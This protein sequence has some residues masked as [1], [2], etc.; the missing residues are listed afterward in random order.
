MN[1]NKRVVDL[2]YAFKC[3]QHLADVAVH[4]TYHRGVD[5]HQPYRVALLTSGQLIPRTCPRRTRWTLN[6]LCNQAE[7]LL[8]R[9][10]LRK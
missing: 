6:T 10:T 5:F 8:A 7:F 4:V 1:S 9:Q 3:L 2:T